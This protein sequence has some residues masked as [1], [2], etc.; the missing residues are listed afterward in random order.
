MVDD[1]GSVLPKHYKL[2]AHAFNATWEK[3]E[4]RYGIRLGHFSVDVRPSKALEFSHGDFGPHG[5][6]LIEIRAKTGLHIGNKSAQQSEHEVLQLH[7]VRY[8]LHVIERHVPIG[9]HRVA[10]Y[11]VEE[12]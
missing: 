12:V 5:K 8:H 4:C 6:V 7:K 11:H 9:Q 10:I 3:A 2:P 1:P